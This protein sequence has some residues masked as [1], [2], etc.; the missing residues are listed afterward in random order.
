VK[1]W[2]GRNSNHT[3]GEAGTRRKKHRERSDKDN[4]INNVPPDHPKIWLRVNFVLGS[5][6]RLLL[7]VG[8][9]PSEPSMGGVGHEK[10]FNLLVVFCCHD[11]EYYLLW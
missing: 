4:Q 3:D 8:R 6:K 7:D 5:K 1:F 10:E 11:V 2:D 9:Y